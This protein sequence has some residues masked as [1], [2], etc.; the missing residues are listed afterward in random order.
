MVF[1]DFSN[2]FLRGAFPVW[3]AGMGQQHGGLRASVAALAARSRSAEVAEAVAGSRP[4]RPLAAVLD[5][6]EVLL[7]NTHLNGFAAPAGAQGGAPV[8][9]HVADFFADPASG[10]RWG[11]ADTSD[12]P[13]PGALELLRELVRCG[14]QPVFVTGRT[15]AVRDVTIADFRRAGFVGGAGAPLSA[16]ALAPGPESVLHMVPDAEAPPP[17]ASIRPF[18]EA[19]RAAVAKDRRI[20]LVV[21]DQVSDLGQHGDVQVLMPHPFYFTP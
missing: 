3:L 12:P 14:V 6:D 11:R 1:V 2:P 8:D 19:Q 5:I 21:G 4:P 10:E 20:F 16:P 17:G 9:F 7:C 18:K 15:E 13:I